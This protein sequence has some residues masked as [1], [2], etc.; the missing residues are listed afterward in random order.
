MKGSLKIN[1]LC[2]LCGVLTGGCLL[3]TKLGFLIFITA[4]PAFYFA[5]KAEKRQRL[6]FCAFFCFA[7]CLVGYFPAF[8]IKTTLPEVTNFLIVG[9]VYLL[10]CIVHG[11]LLTAALYLGFTLPAVKG[12]RVF[13]VSVLY[14]CAEWLMGAGVFAWPTLRLSLALW[15]YPLFLQGAKFGGQLFVSALIVAVNFLL[16]ECFKRE[17]RARK[18]II[19]AA[20]FFANLLFGFLTPAAP[21]ADTEIAVVQSGYTVIDTLRGD[22]YED[23]LTLT[24]EAAKTDAEIIILPESILPVTF[25]RHTFYKA[26]WKA[27]TKE[28]NADILVGGR[29][30]GHSAVYHFKNNENKK[31]YIKSREVPIFEN[32]ANGRQFYWLPQEYCGIMQT[33]KGNVGSMICYESMF[34]VVA[35]DAV[36][37]GAVL[38]CV[39]T[40]DSWFD[41]P[42]AKELHIAH[43]VFRALESGRT[44]VQAG[45]NGK[46]AVIDNN[47]VMQYSVDH[48]EAA[49]LSAKVS[50]EPENTIY[51]FI[52]D[53]WILGL[54]I[55]LAA[56]SVI[57]IREDKKWN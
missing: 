10:I 20:L 52:E 15:R 19:T 7:T 13:Y 54:L 27:A 32:G 11:V 55:L 34:S 45:L 17:K 18:G 24:E 46:T 25:S 50:L 41:S 33:E 47:G 43:G 49:V 14:V 56:G 21:K 53:Y 3:Y 9:A 5:Y 23:T 51:N 48:G 36:E 8:S 6:S 40:N 4:A 57:K 1:A 35:Q 30:D 38:L 16:S 31:I 42:V 44:L 39:L 37:D 26:E 28:T 22:V 29:Q 2:F 12:T